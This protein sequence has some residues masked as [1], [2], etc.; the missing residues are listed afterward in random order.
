MALDVTGVSTVVIKVGTS[1]LMKATGTELDARVISDLA[2]DVAEQIGKGMRIAIV[3]SGAV[4]CGKFRSNVDVQVAAGVGQPILMNAYM[5]EFA[6][7]SKMVTVE[8]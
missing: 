2:E 4:G 1:S 5:K 8:E 3:T 6:K 7:H